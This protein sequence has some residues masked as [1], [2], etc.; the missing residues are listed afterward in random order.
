MYKINNLN[1]MINNVVLRN[2]FARAIPNSIIAVIFAG[3]FLT[4]CQRSD[5]TKK[6]NIIFILTDDQ[7]YGDM[8]IADHP[9][10]KTPNI[11]RLAREGTR[12]TQFYV[13]ATVC[14]PSRVALMTGQFPARN[15]VHHIYMSKKFNRAHGVPDYLDHDVFTVGDVMKKAGYSTAHIGKWHLES[16][17]VASAP[18]N[19]GFDYWLVTHDAS[20]SPIYKERQASTKHFVNKSSNWIIEDAIGYIEKNK[21]SGKPFYLNIWSLVPHG[22]LN[23]TEEELAVY[24]GLKTNPDDFSSWMRDYAGNAKDLNSQMKVFCASMTSLDA[25]IGK[26]LDY[27]DKTGLAENTLIFFTSDNGPEDYHVGDCLNAGVGSSDIFRGRKRSVYE[28]GVRVP[29][30]V[31]WPGHVPAGRVSNSIWSGVDWLPT[32]AN[33]TGVKLPENLS[34][35]GE[36]VTDIFLG[37]EREHTKPLFW[38][39]KYEISGNQQYNPPQ[40]AVRKGDW[41]FLCNPDG[42]SAE[43]Y[44]LKSNP[45]ETINLA[46][47]KP[48]VTKELKGLL[49]EW[50][51][52]IPESAY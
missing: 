3:I 50:K 41:K 10:M 33:I 47:Q 9:Y 8:S 40:L 49:L 52:T 23:P 26:L 5:N 15:N 37:S 21:N 38:E 39:W 11:D 17:D 4:G 7:G 2:L 13:N 25:S 27:L 35:D 19:Y 31:R 34:P 48:E 51:S 28:G 46:T 42:S 14:A 24:D 43:L 12:F 1:E 18:D 44:D 30:V 20:Q 22:L 6:P 29:A 32:L 45:E 36:D 16:R